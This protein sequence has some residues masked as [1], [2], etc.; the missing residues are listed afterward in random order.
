MPRLLLMGG[1]VAQADE[2]VEDEDE[3]E[4][5]ADRGKQARFPTDRDGEKSGGEKS[6]EEGG[7]HPPEELAVNPQQAPSHLDG[8]EGEDQAEAGIKQPVGN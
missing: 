8:P 5:S 7:E 1:E 3:R 6:E 2:F 4:G